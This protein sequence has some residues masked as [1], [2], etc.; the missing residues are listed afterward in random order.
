ML[1][2]QNNNVY[3]SQRVIELLQKH[4]LP[5]NYVII[6]IVIQKGPKITTR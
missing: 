1:V 4:I 2:I 5:T 6:L 3:L